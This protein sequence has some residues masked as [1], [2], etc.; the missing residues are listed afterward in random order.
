MFLSQLRNDLAKSIP[1]DINRLD[2][3]QYY[4]HGESQQPSKILLKL[5]IKSTKNLNERNVD[6]IIKDLDILIK[7]K[8]IT[9][10]SWFNTTNLLD[11][12]FGFQRE[13]K[14][15]VNVCA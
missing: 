3:I 12:D 1:V 2:N 5:L 11:A 13:S 8:D 15:I 6:R 9:L 14:F 7:G 4:K 10:I